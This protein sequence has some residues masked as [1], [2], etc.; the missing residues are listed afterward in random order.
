MYIYIYI[1]G[2]IYIYGVGCL[3]DVG[4][5][6]THLKEPML[7]EAGIPTASCDGT[8]KSFTLPPPADKPDA[9]P[10]GILLLGQAIDYRF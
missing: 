4:L 2:Y 7:K 9:S 6:I 5:M 8:K 3:K 1:H 10:I